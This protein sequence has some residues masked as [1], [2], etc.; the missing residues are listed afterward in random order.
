LTKD[1]V[2][3]GYRQSGGSVDERLGSLSNVRGAPRHLL[4]LESTKWAGT[5]WRCSDQESTAVR[6]CPNALPKIIDERMVSF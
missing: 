1:E 6:R 3:L 5:E 4:P 2:P